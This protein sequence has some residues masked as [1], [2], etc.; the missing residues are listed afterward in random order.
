MNVVTKEETVRVLIFNQEEML[1][2]Q[3]LERDIC[4]Q[5]RSV[6]EVQERFKVTLMM[7]GE[8]LTSLQPAPLRFHE[9]WAEASSMHSDVQHAEMR[10]VA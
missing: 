9:L 8:R 3:C 6:E 10:K 7:E 4:V 2:A 1:V 5:G